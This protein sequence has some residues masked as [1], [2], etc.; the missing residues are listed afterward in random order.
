MQEAS[1]CFS[2][3]HKRSITPLDCGQIPAVVIHGQAK[4]YQ[5]A[6]RRRL[7][8]E[9]GFDCELTGLFSFIYYTQF[10]NSPI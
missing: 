9:M 6:A 4:S 3:E 10:D 5:R 8:E 2:G 1:C 7:N